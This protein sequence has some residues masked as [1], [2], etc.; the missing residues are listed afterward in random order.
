MYDGAIPMMRTIGEDSSKM[1]F[2]IIIDLHKE[3]TLNPRLFTLLN[4]LT[5][6]F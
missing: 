1:L 6:H 2:L 4:E 3:S 5:R